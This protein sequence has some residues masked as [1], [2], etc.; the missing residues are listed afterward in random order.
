MA[1]SKNVFFLFFSETT[2]SIIEPK[3][4]LSTLAFLGVFYNVNLEYFHADDYNFLT[5]TMHE[6]M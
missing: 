5:L 4:M 6:I 2:L 3:K 1:L